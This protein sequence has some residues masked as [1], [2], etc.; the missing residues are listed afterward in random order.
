MRVGVMQLYEDGKPCTNR[1]KCGE[2]SC[3][4]LLLLDL[5]PVHLLVLERSRH[6]WIHAVIINHS[7]L[8][9]IRLSLTCRPPA[10]AGSSRPRWSVG[11]LLL[12][13]HWLSAPYWPSRG[14]V[15]HVQGAAHVEQQG[16]PFSGV[17]SCSFQGRTPRPNTRDCCGSRRAFFSR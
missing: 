2:E 17:P 12:G 15:C 11:N 9:S 7:L 3:R 5:C 4:S 8:L 13:Y 10:C 1:C 16:I 6:S 14:F